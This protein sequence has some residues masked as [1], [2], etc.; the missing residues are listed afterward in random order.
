MR[1]VR[2]TEILNDPLAQ[3][4]LAAPIPARVAYVGL[5]GGPRVVPISV[6]WNGSDIVFAS[7]TNS[8]K[9][10]AL[11]ANP[12]V[13][14]TIDTNVVPQNVLLVRGTASLEIVEG[15]P[16]EYLHASRKVVGDDGMPQFEEQVR[17]LYDQMVLITITAEW[18][19]IMDFETRIPQAVEELAI[20]KFGPK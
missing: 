20:A 9:V 6:Y 2:V 1:P 12:R 13:A 17:A 11:Q 19:K 16:D 18:A 7:A 10:A 3:E 8:A 4:L 15:V 5:D 14:L